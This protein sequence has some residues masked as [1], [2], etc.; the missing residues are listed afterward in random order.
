MCLCLDPCAAPHRIP[1]LSLKPC[2][3]QHAAAMR[4]RYTC[5]QQV[6]DVC[7]CGQQAWRPPPPPWVGEVPFDNSVQY[8]MGAGTLSLVPHGGVSVVC[9]ACGP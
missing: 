2:M 5:R 1:V 4:D 9:L 6:P 7:S 8:V 3:W